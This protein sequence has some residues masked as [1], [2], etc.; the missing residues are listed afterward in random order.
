MSAGSCYLRSIATKSSEA[1]TPKGQAI[2]L[3]VAADNKPEKNVVLA[4]NLTHGEL[5]VS[6][7]DEIAVLPVPIYV[8]GSPG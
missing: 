6:I 4:V 5:E 2:Y 8:T 7:P 1:L 3:N